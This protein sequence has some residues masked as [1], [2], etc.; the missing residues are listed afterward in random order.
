MNSFAAHLSYDCPFTALSLLHPVHISPSP[1]KSAEKKKTPPR[2]G[3]ILITLLV[4]S[5]QEIAQVAM[6]ALLIR[7]DVM[8]GRRDGV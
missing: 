8:A 3:D 7:W 6:L 2:L 4:I 1:C 5:N